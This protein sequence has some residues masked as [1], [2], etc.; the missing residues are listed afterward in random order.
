MNCL[1]KEL[2]MNILMQTDA[3]TCAIAECVSSV[4]RMGLHEWKMMFCKEAKKYV[5]FNIFD[6]TMYTYKIWCAKDVDWQ[7][8]NILSIKRCALKI[9]ELIRRTPT[10]FDDTYLVILMNYLWQGN[11][12]GFK[13]RIT[14]KPHLLLRTYDAVYAPDTYLRKEEP[15]LILYDTEH[16]RHIVSIYGIRPLCW[17]GRNTDPVTP[18]GF[19][20]LLQ[21]LYE[22]HEELCGFDGCTDKLIRGCVRVMEESP[23]YRVD[24]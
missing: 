16:I 24:T 4:M 23:P 19:A 7:S 12:V 3:N 21:E 9:S 20:E 15:Y 18:V 14:E 10:G 22:R 17:L 11:V 6:P 13:R 8:A 1:Q 2:W 5:P